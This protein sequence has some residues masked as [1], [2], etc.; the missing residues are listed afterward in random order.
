MLRIEQLGIQE[1]LFQFKKPTPIYSKLWYLPDFLTHLNI[2][3][4]FYSRFHVS[5]I[6]LYTASYLMPA[7]LKSQF[8]LS[9]FQIKPINNCLNS[10][11]QKLLTIISLCC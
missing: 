9:S 8:E 10:I 2:P 4:L 5:F 6:N 1:I 7:S 11:I 3:Y